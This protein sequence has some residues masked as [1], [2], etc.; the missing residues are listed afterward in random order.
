VFVETNDRTNTVAV[1][2]IEK[3]PGRGMWA[4]D[5]REAYA[6]AGKDL[7]ILIRGKIK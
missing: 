3:M 1:V 5:M 7:G 4:F 6:K 2:Q